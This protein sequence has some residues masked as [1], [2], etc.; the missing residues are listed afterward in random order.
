MAQRKTLAA[1]RE[2]RSM[3]QEEVGQVLGVSGAAYS[4]KERGLRPLSLK[5]AQ[6]LADLFGVKLDDIDF[7]THKLTDTVSDD[8]QAANTL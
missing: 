5:E 8:E 3:T 6:Q 2:E 4:R 7:F 1:L